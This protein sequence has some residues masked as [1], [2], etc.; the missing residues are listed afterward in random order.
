[1]DE[2]EALIKELNLVF[3]GTM[4]KYEFASPNFNLKEKLVEYKNCISLY[5]LISDFN[6][7][8]NAFLED[9][10]KL[11][12]LKKYEM[13]SMIIYTSYPNERYRDL[14]LYV[15]SL[16]SEYNTIDLCE[17]NGMVD[18]LAFGPMDKNA[19][20]LSLKERI[21]THMT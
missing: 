9:Y 4:D 21:P 19:K 3:T 10:H 13:A 14:T 1:M 18:S 20:D 2:L 17:K 15:P 5:K 7:Q 8:Y 16:H 6:K 11:D 12:L